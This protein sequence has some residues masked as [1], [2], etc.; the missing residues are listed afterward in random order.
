MARVRG[1][2]RPNGRPPSSL[3]GK[4]SIDMH[5]KG[6]PVDVI[7]KIDVLRQG[8]ETRKDVIVRIV[9]EYRYKGETDVS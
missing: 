6:M 1:T 7:M 9:R 4:E 2:G 3:E 8:T 5:M